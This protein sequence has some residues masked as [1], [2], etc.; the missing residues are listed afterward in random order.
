MQEQNR[1]YFYSYLAVSRAAK[2]TG[3][4]VYDQILAWKGAVAGRQ[5]F[6]R[7]MRR[8][9]HDQPQTLKIYTDLQ[10]ATRQ[11]GKLI[12]LV[13][14][15]GQRDAHQKRLADLSDSVESLQQ[16]LAGAS[17]AFAEQRQQ[18]RRTT[19]VLQQS[20]PAGTA[21]VDI[22]EYSH[23][24]YV[25]DLDKRPVWKHRYTAFVLRRDKPIVWID[26]GLAIEPI[27]AIQTWRKTYGQ[28]T[29]AE[30][31]AA[32]LRKDIWEP[33]QEALVGA[34]TVL[35]S[36]DGALSKF[37][38][39][40][41][42]GEK[43]GTYLIE[44][45]SIAVIPFPQMLPELLSRKKD[46]AKK[47]PASLLL[48]GDVD[49]GGDSG[50]MLASAEAHRGERAVRD[51]KVVWG[52]LKG[53]RTEID[54]IR[55]CFERHFSKGKANQLSDKEATHQAVHE[56][57]IKNRFLHFATHGFFADASVKSLSAPKDRPENELFRENSRA[58]IV[59]NHPGL[60]SGIVLTGANQP[61][62]DDKD[63]G[64]LTALEVG[65]L[66]LDG[67][68]LAT[69]SACETGLGKTAGGEGLLGL[70]RAFQLAGAKTTVASLWKVP[71]QA[72]KSLMVR[73]YGNLW[74]GK[75]SKLDAL[76][77]AQRWLLNEGKQ[78]P[79]LYRGLESADASADTVRQDG[80]LTPRYWAAFILSG[81]WR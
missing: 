76:L 12:N 39:A 46:D 65:E 4:S 24:G 64:I 32:K 69:L 1:H 43:P 31:A 7:A 72:T 79:E 41:L 33:L 10:D 37:P 23:F 63:D 80:R 68:E 15:E 74:S 61:A 52:P 38:F 47:S 70:Q 25:R 50:V 27:I 35:I 8:D 28:G 77:N 75:M 59:G 58:P 5:T 55:D 81:D 56:Q 17:A 78:H 13:P 49:Y 67:V 71:D 18:Q 20:L 9:L 60:L 29:E 66:D 2:S 34:N 40:A 51:G 62:A 42:P 53:T 3:V 48:V 21:L 19:A 11:L 14:K 57:A 16:K 22:L 6:L 54:A 26:L 45:R 44:E 36:P 73:F 30:Q